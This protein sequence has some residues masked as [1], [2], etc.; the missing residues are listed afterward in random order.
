MTTSQDRC[1]AF[2]NVYQ[3]Q[4]QPFELRDKNRPGHRKIVALFLVDPALVDPRPSTTTVAPQQKEWVTAL[5]DVLG[6]SPSSLISRLPVE[7]RTLIVDKVEGL[8][9]REEAEEYRLKL[10]DERGAMAKVN[11]QEMFEVPF[12]MC[13]H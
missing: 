4:V 6:S 13:E 1:L 7:L 12:A 9:T 2:P 11:T 3:H 5:F 8:M 10:M